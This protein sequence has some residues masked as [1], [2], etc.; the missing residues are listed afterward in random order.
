MT[1]NEAIIV[2]NILKKHGYGD[3]HM[4]VESGWS[5][6]GCYPDEVNSKKKYIDMEGYYDGKGFGCDK[7]LFPICQEIKEALQK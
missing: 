1:V 4:T 3:C 2:C 6:L 5:S 7:E